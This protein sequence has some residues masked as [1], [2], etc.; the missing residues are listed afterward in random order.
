MTRLNRSRIK[1]TP[2]LCGTSCT[3]F[4][5]SG[6]SLAGR[7][8][9]AQIYARTVRGKIAPIKVAQAPG[10]RFTRDNCEQR[11]NIQPA[12]QCDTPAACAP[13][14]QRVAPVTARSA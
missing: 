1:Y 2:G 7:V 3:R 12:A 10:L 9:A 14:K 13:R 5:K 6:F 8:I 4:C 11:G